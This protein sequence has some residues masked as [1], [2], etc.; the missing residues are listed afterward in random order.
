MAIDIRDAFFDEIYDIAAKDKNVMFV[1]A[2][3]DAFSIRRYKKDFP[4]QF[5]NVGVQEQNMVLIATG[6]ALAGKKVF[7]YSIIPFITMRC[8]EH[9]KANICS[10]N[11]DVTIIGCGAGLSFSKDGPTHHAIHDIGVMRVMPDMK[12]YNPSDAESAKDCAQKV[13]NNSTPAYVRI[14][15][16]IFPELYVDGCSDANII[17]NFDKTV[18]ISTGYMTHT[19]LEVAEELDCGLIDLVR[20]SPLPENLFELIRERSYG[21]TQQIITIEEN[22]ITGGIG[23]AVSE[24]IT[25]HDLPIKLKRIALEDKQY[26]E[27]GD[28]KWLHEEYGISANK[29]ISRLRSEIGEYY[30][31]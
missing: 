1:T 28:R 18:I 29:I 8:Y 16:G 10:M 24:F 3:A 27:Y 2:D 22:S 20:I 21:H 31:D 26:F 15:K 6:L 9:I 12:I 11:L 7:V 17:R 23:S 5:I 13:Y 19:A 30:V 25:D 4:D 14:D